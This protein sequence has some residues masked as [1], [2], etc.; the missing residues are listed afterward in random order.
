MKRPKKEPETPA[1]KPASTV[2]GREQQLIAA[3]YDAVE[4]RI[5]NGTATSAEYVHFLKLGSSKNELESELLRVQTELAKAKEEA[6]RFEKE[7]QIAYDKV[8]EVI[9]SYGTR[10][11]HE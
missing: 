7:H 2:R 4:E 11:A 6:I 1:A 3:A 9:K 10:G 5:R 8:V